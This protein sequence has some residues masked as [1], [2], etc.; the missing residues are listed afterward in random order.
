[1]ATPTNPGPSLLIS[2][3]ASNLILDHIALDGNI[4]PRRVRYNNSNWAMDAAGRRTAMNGVIHAC[5]G[6]QFLGF[7]STRAAQGSGMEFY[8][9]NA[10]FDG[11]LFSENGWGATGFPNS[12]AD[13]LTLLSSANAKVVNS[14][15]I[16]NSDVDLI[17]GGAPNLIVSSNKFINRTN[18]SFAALM[19][20]NFQN[21]QSGI[22]TNAIISNNS[23]DCSSGMCGIGI[24][25]GPHFWY[26]SSSIN[27]TG[28]LVSNN[29]I[30][31]AKQGILTAGAIGFSI[32][33]NIINANGAY[34]GENYIGCT[35]NPLSVS[36]G[37]SVS[38]S[39]NNYG[40]F[41]NLLSG[42]G[43][44][45]L[46]RLV[47]HM[48]N[49]SYTIAAD[50]RAILG[51]DADASGGQYF[52]NLLASEAS[53]NSDISMQMASSPESFNTLNA[54]Y[55]KYLGRNIDSSGWDAHSRSLANGTVTVDQLRVNIQLSS[56]ALSNP[57]R[58]Y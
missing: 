17:I 23:I 44:L 51:R 28:S 43:P 8:G 5:S 32:A 36:G 18:F 7:T 47:V 35:A 54:M 56:E 10:V 15:F 6:C 11:A 13:G 12:W 39:N 58:V 9:D 26:Q 20:D 48:A 3:N 40:V 37:D 53:N 46:T 4:A 1:M 30:T 2:T 45:D 42:C 33:S 50:Y 41:P 24:D 49:V 22:F 55:Q 27:G 16:D 25:L 31:G 29:T 57:F 38:V 19:L 34:A 52:S 14:K 21:S